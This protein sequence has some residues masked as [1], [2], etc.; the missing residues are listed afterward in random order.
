MSVFIPAIPL[1]VEVWHLVQESYFDLVLH[2]AVVPCNT[3]CQLIGAK[4]ATFAYWEWR[5]SCSL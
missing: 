2:G 1:L 3:K 4:P 5:L